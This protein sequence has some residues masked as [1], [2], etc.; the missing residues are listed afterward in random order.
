MAGLE[1]ISNNKLVIGSSVRAFAQR[2]LSGT[3]DPTAPFTKVGIKAVAAEAA[4]CFG[5]ENSKFSSLIASNRL[6]IAP[7]NNRE[8]VRGIPQSIRQKFSGCD[9]E[10][11]TSL[12]SLWQ[13]ATSKAETGR[14]N[15][16]PSQSNS[17]PNVDANALLFDAQKGGHKPDWQYTHEPA[18]TPLSSVVRC[19]W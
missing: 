16:S 3:V 12:S 4:T 6:R 17:I 2:R 10:Y 18:E 14:T 5:I 13:L 8:V 19:N 7:K 11:V 1:T 9:K 15:L